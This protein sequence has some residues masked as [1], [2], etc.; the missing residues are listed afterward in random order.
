MSNA[1]L[2]VVLAEDAV[3]LREGLIDV[4]GRFGHEV[5]A[6]V[7]D[8]DALI[9]A[10]DE[11]KPDVVV[12][13]VRMPPGFTDEGLRATVALRS[14][15]PDLG[16]L[17]LTQYLATAY[18]FELLESCSR[19]GGGLGYMLKERVGA[20]A[21]FVVA[22]ERIA[23]GGMV[24]DPDVVRQL[25]QRQ[26]KNEPLK[27]LTLRER[28]VL[29]LMAEG[30]NNATIAAELGVTPAAVAKNI[31]NIFIKLHLSEASGHRRV[32][33]VLSYLRQ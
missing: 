17:V 31:G 28:E 4:L 22:V 5:V 3:L 27:R 26:Q 29:G 8:A 25:L 10:V 24:I 14:R 20:V 13:D 30:N 12:T 23:K 2:R 11:V 6:A 33:A 1:G 19:S 15:Y 18:A 16:V 32:L 21:E 7:G 9:S